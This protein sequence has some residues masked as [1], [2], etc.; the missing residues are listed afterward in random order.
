MET[1]GAK[2][3]A[4]TERLR[5]LSAA[6]GLSS[7]TE[8]GTAIILQLVIESEA[9]IGDHI[10]LQAISKSIKDKKFETEE[11]VERWI[12]SGVLAAYELGRRNISVDKI[13]SS[14]DTY[15]KKAKETMEDSSKFH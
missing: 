12:S 10:P 3:Q 9:R 15:T 13:L 2:H 4:Q 1:P 11:D 7:T 8:F 5:R 14:F 6:H